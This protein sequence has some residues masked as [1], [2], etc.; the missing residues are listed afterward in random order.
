MH[1][2]NKSFAP[3][4]GFLFF[5]VFFSVKE[6]HL[7]DDL[8]QQLDHS[9]LSAYWVTENDTKKYHHELSSQSH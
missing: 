5:S 2:D 3:R 4:R 8:V 7:F 6:Q 1:P 9:E